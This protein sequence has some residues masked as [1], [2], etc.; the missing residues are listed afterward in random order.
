[1]QDLAH[2]G[3]ALACGAFHLYLLAFDDGGVWIEVIGVDGGNE[4]LVVGVF[5]VLKLELVVAQLTFESL[6]FLFLLGQLLAQGEDFLDVFQTAGPALDAVLD[7][8][9]VVLVETQLDLPVLLNS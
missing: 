6:R 2:R 9:H 8:F 7:L 5:L 4:Y 1:M 3:D